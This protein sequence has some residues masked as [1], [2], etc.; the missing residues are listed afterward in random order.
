MRRPQDLGDR[1]T[2][3]AETKQTIHRRDGRP[4]GLG[5]SNYVG[6]DCDPIPSTTG[7]H[8]PSPR[9]GDFTWKFGIRSPLKATYLAF[10]RPGPFRAGVRP[11]RGVTRATYSY[12]THPP[13]W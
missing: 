10:I 6:A 13:C 2:A 7:R 11:R 1:A 4:T 3:V 12:D 8:K 9:A 5:G